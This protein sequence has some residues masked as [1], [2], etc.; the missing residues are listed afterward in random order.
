MV[1]NSSSATCN[2]DMTTLPIGTTLNQVGL[3]VPFYSL[4]FST[5]SAGYP[6]TGHRVPT[7][8]PPVPLRERR[9]VEI[10]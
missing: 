6:G 9:Q 2:N 10:I 7:Y 4:Y 5:G 8:I 3:S 1:N